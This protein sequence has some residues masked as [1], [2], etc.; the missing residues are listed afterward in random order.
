[1]LIDMMEELKVEVILKGEIIEV[2]KNGVSLV[3]E[4]ENRF[5]EGHSLVAAGRTP[6][7]S[8]SQALKE[9]GKP[10]YEVGDCQSPRNV[11]YAILDGFNV[12]YF[13]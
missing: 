3:H 10:F 5:L 9:K 7:R 6:L 11:H 2:N 8:L 4:G 12:G 13:I 1:M